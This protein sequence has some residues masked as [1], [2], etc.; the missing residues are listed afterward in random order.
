[1]FIRGD[2]NSSSVHENLPLS[3]SLLRKRELASTEKTAVEKKI[4]Q[5]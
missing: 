1:M 2:Y 3:C 5:A 4:P